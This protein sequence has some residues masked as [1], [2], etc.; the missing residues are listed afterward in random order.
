MAPISP[1]QSTIAGHEPTSQDQLGLGYLRAFVT[2][3]VVAHHSFLAYVTIAPKPGVSLKTSPFWMVFPVV[4]VRRSPI[5]DLFVGFNDSFFMSL[6]F[7]I[8]GCFVWKSLQ[9]KGPG[10]FAND[11]ALRLGI[12]FVVATAIVPLI[13]YYPAYLQM[14]SAH[15]IGDFVHQWLNLGV[16][17]AGPAWFVWILLAFDC[18]IALCYSRARHSES[19]AE[20]FTHGFASSPV[21][22]F[23]L[24]VS[25]SAAVYI[26]A[27][28][29]Y[30]ALAWTQHGPFAFQTARLGHYFAYFLAGVSL[31]MVGLDRGFLSPGSKFSQRWLR[32]SLISLLTL[33]FSFASGI[34]SAQHPTN[35][36]L[37]ILASF[38]FVLCCAAAC[39]AFLAI[40]LHFCQRR[41]TIFESFKSNAYGV[42]LIHYAFVT[43]LQYLLLPEQLPSLVKA[44]FVCIGTVVLSWI[45]VSIMRRVPFVSRMI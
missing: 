27:S 40:F 2:L 13:A 15:S 8:S 12:P 10:R 19:A 31:G 41:Y 16:W 35:T 44:L 33:V 29:T 14:Q 32:W 6:M 30:G 25:V 39:F 23:W 36:L 22:F 4:D 26:P 24:L 18:V 20:F 7:L 11:R 21:R 9:K 3:L 38:G 45:T 17:P 28:L 37:A 34:I 5:A 42:Y 43:W 1:S